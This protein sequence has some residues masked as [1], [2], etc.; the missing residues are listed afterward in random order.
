MS[1]VGNP[2]YHSYDYSG[3]ININNSKIVKLD[4]AGQQCVTLANKLNTFCEYIQVLVA[5]VEKMMKGTGEDAYWQGERAYQ[6]YRDC[7]K[8]VDKTV[9][10]YLNSVDVFQNYGKVLSGA[11]GKSKGKEH[12]TEWLAKT[13]SMIK[14]KNLISTMSIDI[15][16]TVD[17]NASSDMTNNQSR[18]CYRAIIQDLENIISQ[19]NK[20]SQS[21]DDISRNA[22]GGLKTYSSRRID[23]LKNRMSELKDVK[24][25]LAIN[26]LGD[27]LFND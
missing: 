13:K 9:E 21:W 5:D 27:C 2:A 3:H 17:R 18:A 22:K 16:G 14:V 1:N 4:K 20:L 26:Y 24:S 6:W 19:Y 12:K 11:M 25:S 15:P 7:K 10:N 23:A 8:Y